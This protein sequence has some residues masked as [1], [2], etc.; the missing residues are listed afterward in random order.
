MQIFCRSLNNSRDVFNVSN[1]P[2]GS[3]DLDICRH[4]QSERED[5]PEK[6]STRRETITSFPSTSDR[7]TSDVFFSIQVTKTSDLSCA[8]EAT[9][10]Q[11]RLLRTMFYS[12]LRTE[13]VPKPRRRHSNRN[14]ESFCP[15][16][17]GSLRCVGERDER[18]TE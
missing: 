17:S 9:L 14:D 5:S 2:N 13:E 1:K 3:F 6:K 10:E 12:D 4:Q 16:S 8:S 11:N 15:F 7:I 18:G